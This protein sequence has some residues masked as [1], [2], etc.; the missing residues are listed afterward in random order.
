MQINEIFLSVQA[1]SINTLGVPQMFGVGV[2]T[3]FVRTN[4]CRLCCIYC[5]TSYTWKD[6]ETI[7]TPDEVITKVQEASG[8]Y[9]AVCITGGEP[10]LSDRGEMH[11]LIRG[12]REKNYVISIEASGTADRDFFFGAD[13]IV[14][15]I[16]GPSAG[17]KAMEVSKDNVKHVK[18]LNRYDQLKFL[19]ADKND[20]N[21]MVEWLEKTGT[22]NL[23]PSIRPVI[24]VSPVF[25]KKGQNNA[26]Q[27]VAWM[28]EK[29][30]PAVLNFQIHKVIWPI[31]QR[32]V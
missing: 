23:D 26:A 9:R 31:E 15:D 11:Q 21:W 24:L 30:L 5:D 7:M 6:E 2:P 28:L 17:K 20:F 32:G 16:K 13:S 14:M 1:E 12:L 18:T 19:V 25:D 22:I 8:P 3:V 27:V 10:E 4:K 29:K